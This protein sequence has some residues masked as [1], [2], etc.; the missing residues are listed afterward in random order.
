[1]DLPRL[2]PEQEW[3]LHGIDIGSALFPPK[4][5]PYASLDLR[6][7]DIRSPIP[8]AWS[9]SQ[10][11]D[12]VHQRLLIWGLQKP[13]WP[14]VIR[15]HASLLK[16]GGWIQLV[17]GEWVDHSRPV[18]AEKCPRIAKM[19]VLMEWVSNLGNDVF[20]ANHLE[21]LLKDAG[22]QDVQKTQ[23]DLGYGAS[24]KEEQ[25]KRPSAESWIDLFKGLGTKMPEGGIPGVAR[26]IEEFNQFL[27]ELPAEVLKW[28][29]T[30]KLN[31]VIGQKPEAGL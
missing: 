13:D 14:V 3:S 19:F 29:Y 11:F 22:F 16:P 12:L 27:N 1:M 4:I 5:G 9:W 30:P 17:E 6:A 31:F 21:D 7:H 25:W 10:S 20:V 28:G 23:F 15:N 18:D 2:Y 8:E 24:A 26:D